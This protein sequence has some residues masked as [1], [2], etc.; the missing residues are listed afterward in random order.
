[1]SF[2]ERRT[3][4][5]DRVLILLAKYL[6]ST[7]RNERKHVLNNELEMRSRSESFDPVLIAYSKHPA[8]RAPMP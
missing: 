5:F 4:R 8:Y 2:Y 6:T 3:Q 1:M 7:D